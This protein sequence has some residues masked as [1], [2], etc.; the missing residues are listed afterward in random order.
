M[1]T[2]NPEN[3]RTL[4]TRPCEASPALNP[5]ATLLSRL[6]EAVDGLRLGAPIL[7]I[8]PFRYDPT[9]QG[10]R[11]IG[12]FHDCEAAIAYRDSKGLDP[13]EFGV[14]GP[15]YTR[16]PRSDTNRLGTVRPRVE[17]VVLHLEGGGEICLDGTKYD[18]VFWGDASV[19]K[20][21]VPYYAAVG[22]VDEAILLRNQY[23]DGVVAVVHLPGS[24]WVDAQDGD[25]LCVVQHTEDGLGLFKLTEKDV[26]KA[27]SGSIVGWALR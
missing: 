9:K 23:E 7:L 18:A 6:A 3:A 2:E 27:A 22:T 1:A 8:A 16:L 25:N 14:F 13:N 11:V 5:S 26:D 17:K 10:H 19:D 15:F 12:P 20:F 4:A 21:L 24:E